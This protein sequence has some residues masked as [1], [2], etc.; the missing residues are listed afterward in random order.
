MTRDGKQIMKLSGKS[1]VMRLLLTAGI[2]SET[3]NSEV[4]VRLHLG[5]KSDS[6]YAST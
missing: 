3:V 6:P 4:A 5:Y 1:L 2:Y